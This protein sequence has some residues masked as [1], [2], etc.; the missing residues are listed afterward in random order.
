MDQKLKIGTAVE[1]NTWPEQ[2]QTNE[3]AWKIGST[4]STH[5]TLDHR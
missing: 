4:H 5:E 2:G 1:V 3:E